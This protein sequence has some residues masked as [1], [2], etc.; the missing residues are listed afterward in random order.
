MTKL[1]YHN[2]ANN[3]VIRA[4]AAGVIVAS[5][6]R[7][8]ELSEKVKVF[9]FARSLAARSHFHGAALLIA[10]GCCRVELCTLNHRIIADQQIPRAHRHKHID[11]SSVCFLLCK[12]LLVPV[13]YYMF[14]R[15]LASLSATSTI[16]INKL[17]WFMMSL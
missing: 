15:F 13:I 2:Y 10:I 1:V 3:N 14:I 16:L 8:G 9:I 5:E 4:A 6:C 7:R 11:L 12:I 17:R